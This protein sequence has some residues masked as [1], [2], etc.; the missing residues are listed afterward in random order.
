V[1]GGSKTRPYLLAILL[2]PKKAHPH[3]VCVR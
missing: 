1:W 2:V 3:I